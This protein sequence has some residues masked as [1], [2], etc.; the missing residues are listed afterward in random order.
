MRPRH[1]DRLHDPRGQF[2][3]LDASRCAF[4]EKDLKGFWGWF[5]SYSQVSLRRRLTLP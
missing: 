2:G 5:H 4:R 3:D 1:R